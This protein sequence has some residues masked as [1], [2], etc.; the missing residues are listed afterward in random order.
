MTPLRAVT[1]DE[2]AGTAA[3]PSVQR[4]VIIL[5]NGLS[6]SSVLAGLIAAAG[7]WTGDD[8]FKKADYDTYENSELIALNLQLLREVEYNGNFTMVYR[9]EEIHEI[10]EKAADVDP[11]P[12]RRFVEN[13]GRHHPW[14]W[15]DPRL[16]L[17]MRFWQRLLDLE[18]VRFV[19][20]R[21]DHEQTWI[22]TTLRRQIQ[23]PEYA[24][25]YQDGI[26]SS[27][28][29]FL[30]DNNLTYMDVIYEDLLVHPQATIG[31]LNAFLGSGITMH[32]LKQVYHGPLYRK[33]RS[34]LDY[35]KANLIY[36]KNYAERY[37]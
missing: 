26:T 20:M 34:R 9:P 12:Y 30:W 2:H 31:K 1:P 29:Q 10:T 32:H 7:Y 19:L 16:W 13:C 14:I 3:K 33:Q 36:F 37:R 35:L 6:G 18:R 24:R 17:T 4:N 5:T 8:T 28:L 15:K 27:I 22:S 23:T 21:R 25:N 11:A